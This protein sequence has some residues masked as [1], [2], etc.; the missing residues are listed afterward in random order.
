MEPMTLGPA[1][2]I[3]FNV[4]LLAFWLFAPAKA[5]EAQLNATGG[6]L[7][8]I[9]AK[10]VLFFGKVKG[11]FVKKAVAAILPANPS[12]LKVQDIAGTKVVINQPAPEVKNQLK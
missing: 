9:Y 7:Q 12:A 2:L 10:L 8:W 3:I 6:V 4:L 1:L 11:L 5:V